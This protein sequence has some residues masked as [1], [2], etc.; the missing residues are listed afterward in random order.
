VNVEISLQNYRCFPEHH[1]AKFRIGPGFT[2]FVGPNNSGKSTLLRFF[3][4]FRNLF[5]NIGNPNFLRP[6]LIGQG[7]S[8]V[9]ADVVD[10]QE[11]FSRENDLSIELRIKLLGESDQGRLVSANEF[12]FTIDRDLAVRLQTNANGS[13][14]SPDETA[15]LQN[16]QLFL[17]SRATAAADLSEILAAV[18]VLAGSRYVGAF[19]NVLN[20]TQSRPYFDISVGVSVVL[21]WRDLK[22]GRNS[23]NRQRALELEQSIRSIFGFDAFSLDAA[24][25]GESF[26]ARIN[27]QSFRL[28]E[29]GSGLAQFV[30]VF[31]AAA[32]S[33]GSVLLIDEPESNLHPSLQIAFLTA[34]AAEYEHGV[35][36][37]THNLGLARAI[38]PE[39]YSFQL[40][41]DGVSAVRPFENDARL[42]ELLGELSFGAYQDLGHSR[43]L[44][45]EG[46][47]EVTAVSV[48]LR[49]LGKD[50]EVVL[51][52]LSGDSLINAK[53]ARQLAEIKRLSVNIGALIDSEKKSEE[54]EIEKP[55]QRF[56]HNC[57]RLG[58][59]CHVLERRAFEN[60][61]PERAIQEVK[62]PKYRALAAFEASESVGS[63]FWDK[64]ENW[65]ICQR[66]SK[67]EF[68][69]T[70]DLYTFLSD[71]TS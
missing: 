29:L 51:L 63:L 3:Y 4:E 12:I 66:M 11:V 61:L 15:V 33:K 37:A 21:A 35:V 23:R 2:A 70:Q 30:L 68:E 31:L 18:S 36:F 47:S 58:I 54:A 57:A 60:Y 28:D 40:I 38:A 71:F 6:L 22:T 42:P 56:A 5:L 16:T 55:R 49:K 34:L 44:L 59:K 25:D 67:K 41:S 32:T 52:P 50:Q 45:V 7:R 17:H 39:I 10:S 48:L 1:P 65:R 69:E 53:T 26:V 24:D 62:G 9:L 19:R 27:D 64:D 8:I 20:V 43:I 46:P 13:L 14:L